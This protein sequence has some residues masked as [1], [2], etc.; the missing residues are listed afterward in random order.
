MTTIEELSHRK[1]FSKNIAKVEN[2]LVGEQLF[3]EKVTPNMVRS[4]FLQT[5]R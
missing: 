2:F 4:H 3:C 5:K 1:L